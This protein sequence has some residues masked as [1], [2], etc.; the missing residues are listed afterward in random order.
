MQDA[1]KVLFGQNLPA[2]IE[3]ALEKLLVLDRFERLYQSVGRIGDERSFVDR[4]L[5]AMNVRP[6]V[7]QID[8]QLIPRDGPVVAVAN[9]PFGLVEGTVL[10]ALL[11][12]IRP[13]VKILANRLLETLPEARAHCIFV[14]P[15]GG[16]QALPANL[17]GL[18]SAI[19]WLKQGGLLAVFPAG[20]V[21]HLDLKERAVI[22]P[23]WNQNIAR[24]I[25]LTSSTVLPVY[26]VGANSAMFQLLGFLH[27]RVRTALLAHELLNKHDTTIELRIGK[28]IKAAKLKTFQDDL[29]M[30]RYMRHRTYL[31]QNRK[32]AKPA[33]RFTDQPSTV[34]TDLCGLMA[35]EIALLCQE[36]ILVETEEYFVLLAKASEI[37]KV[38]TEIGRLREIAF[39]YAG[40]G[41]G[42]SIDLDSFDEYYW[43]LF[44]WNRIANEVVSAYRFGASDEILPRMGP[45]G[46]YT[47][48]LFSWKPPFLDRIHPALE[49]G[50]SFVRLEYQK[51]FA[52]L[53]LLWR[54]IGQF[55]VRNPRYRILFGPVSISADYTN[56][57]R[58]LIVKFLNTYYQSSTLS[59]LVRARNPF[60]VT[61]SR[62]THELVNT[63]VWDIEELSA[64]VADIEIDRKGVPILL[65]QYL[66]LGGELVAFNVDRNFANALDGLIVVD[67]QKTDPR[68]LERYMGAAGAAA[69]LKETHGVFGLS[70][71]S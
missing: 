10:A 62:Q 23:E 59:P 19:A 47:N 15:F 36:R 69:F 32:A 50:R 60:R 2:P 38:L 18:K 55:L 53:L 64:L 24:L 51:S 30:T 40:E 9:H 13:D 8:L 12:S 33:R 52:P 44:V 11:G 63:A 66:K 16:D 27:P 1:L 4:F 70:T 65:K 17:R 68:V 57:S 29:A 56:A 58:E 49:L 35:A 39:R 43:H 3:G 26:F 54:G 48:Q 5:D 37:P 25:R 28:P 14:D 45:K 42:Q 34:S 21:A 41:T 22:D 31:L 67:L 46:L 61:P 7:S 6:S 71:Q 20:E